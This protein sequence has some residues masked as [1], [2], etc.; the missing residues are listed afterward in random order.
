MSNTSQIF[1]I[2]FLVS[3]FSQIHV[4]IFKSL[5]ATGYNTTNGQRNC[6]RSCGNTSIPFPFG[7][8]PECS[9]NINFQLN[10]TSNQPLIGPL[11][12]QY[13]VVNISVDEG[14][15]VVNKTYDTQ[16]PSNEM[17]DASEFLEDLI[18]K[19][20]DLSEEY[21]IWKW[22]ISN[23][24]CGMAKNKNTTSYACISENSEC[25]NLTHEHVY[26]GYRCKCSDGYEGNPYIRNGCNGMRTLHLS[27]SFFACTFP[28]KIW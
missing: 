6:S 14:L 13:Q 1:F 26:I 21:G 20:M 8:E 23:I 18:M 3:C 28:C 27:S 2:L 7:L 9:A 5:N 19:D 11:Y 17:M 24:T 16:R 15:L 4:F 25:T 10:C 12:E 22:A